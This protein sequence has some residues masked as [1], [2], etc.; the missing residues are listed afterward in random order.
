MICK[1]Q[2]PNPNLETAV[3]YNEDK[4]KGRKTNDEEL[5]AI[6]EGRVLATRNVPEGK[7]LLEVFQERRLLSLKNKRRG[8][9]L[10]AMTFHMSVN[11]S[12]NDTSLSEA[13]AVAFMDELME[14]LGY[15]EQPYRIYEHTDIARRHYHVVSCRIDGEGKKIKD[16]FERRVLRDLLKRLA[17][18]YGYSV[19]LSEDEKRQAGPTPEE[20]TKKPSK[21]KPIEESPRKKF[22]PA[23]S[24]KSPHPVTTQLKDIA[25]DALKWHFSTF[26]QFQALLLRRYNVLLEVEA[27]PEDRLYLSGADANGN[28]ITAP[29][30]ADELGLRLLKDIAEKTGK[31]KMRNRKEQRSYLE[32][33]VNEALEAADSYASFCK[34]LSAKGIIPVLSFTKD[35][36]L[37]GLTWLD[38]ATRCAWKASETTVNMGWFRSETKGRGWEVTADRHQGVIDRHGARPSR[39]SAPESPKKAEPRIS[40]G[41]KP[42][43]VKGGAVPN[44]RPT[45]EYIPPT[46]NR[47]TASTE[48]VLN[49]RGEDFKRDDDDRPAELVK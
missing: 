33:R 18:K 16:S 1:I 32:K 6:E 4:A 22:V 26:E 47:T 29:I 19:I 24:R 3:R 28:P 46:A 37:F 40:T 30:P 2:P 10:T 21:P 27:G 35:G 39:K 17:A 8:P 12:D 25:E 44:R 7:E 13:D 23:F 15:K 41:A 45:N 5:Q 49:R 14:G 48:S 43:P 42:R 36:T 20:E 34:E 9:K 38:R 31:E 11:P